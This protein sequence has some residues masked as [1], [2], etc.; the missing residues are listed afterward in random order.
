MAEGKKRPANE[1]FTT[2]RG[3]AVYPKLNTPDEYKGKRS[4]NV[5]LVLARGAV[6]D[7]VAK[8]E[9]VAEKAYQDSKAKLEEKVTSEKGAKKGEAKAKLAKLTK[10]DFPMKPQYDEEGSETDNVI[11]NFKMAA[12]YEKDGKTIPI[13]PRIFDAK[14]AMLKNPPEIWGGSILRVSGELVPFDMPAKDCAGVSLRLGAVQIIE[15]RTR[16]GGVSADS[17]GF[18]KEEGYEQENE[19]AEEGFADESTTSTGS[20]SAEDESGDPTNF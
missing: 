8:A 4:Y 3:I 17:Y 9:A 1:K 15:L 16:G 7:L 11:L 20:G 14:G 2:P 12:S 10:A 13:S 5:K 18:E 6:A 19:A